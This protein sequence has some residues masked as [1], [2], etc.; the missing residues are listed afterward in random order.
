M[1][2]LLQ[3]K[4]KMAHMMIAEFLAGQYPQKAAI[5]ALLQP[6]SGFP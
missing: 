3:L 5:A 1:E 6:S 4:R 2:I